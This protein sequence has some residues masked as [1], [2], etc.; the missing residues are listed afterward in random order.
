MLLSGRSALPAGAARRARPAAPNV[1]TAPRML[2]HVRLEV[3][4]RRPCSHSLS[5]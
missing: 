3:G 2:P 4:D 5:S 1:R